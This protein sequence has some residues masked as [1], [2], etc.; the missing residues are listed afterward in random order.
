MAKIAMADRLTYIGLWCLTD[1]AGYLEW[2]PEQIAGELYRHED[3]RSRLEHVAASLAELVE[4]GRVRLL[5]CGRHALIPTIPEYRIGGG[6]MLYT[7]KK[8]HDKRCSYV[9]LRSTTD[10]S[11]SESLSESDSESSH[12]RTREGVSPVA[13]EAWRELGQIYGGRPDGH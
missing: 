12:A 4:R 6:A 3:P 5:S 1:D 7:I 10:R 9:G 2:D 13:E 11:A 8:R